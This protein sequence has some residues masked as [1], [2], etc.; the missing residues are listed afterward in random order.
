MGRVYREFGG[1]RSEQNVLL[2]YAESA[3][4]DG[5]NC[6]PS[7]ARIAYMTDYEVR[8]VKRITKKLRQ[9]NVLQVVREASGR[10]PTEYEIHLEKAP[11]KQT[12]E[13]WKEARE[14]SA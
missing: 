6:R 2:A 5:T 13:E 12:F 1:T 10:R 8:N 9:R 7:V 3:D 11:K 14:E 4:D